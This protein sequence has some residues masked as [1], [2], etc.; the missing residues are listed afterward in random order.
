MD[1][2]SITIPLVGVREHTEGYP[3][4]LSRN[5]TSGR[6]V[7]EALNECGNR[8]TEVDLCD[9]IDWCRMGPSQ[10]RVEGLGFRFMSG[11]E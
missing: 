9:L 3:V 5:A 1:Q 2:N 6:L 8:T 4:H 10:G 11:S 7:I